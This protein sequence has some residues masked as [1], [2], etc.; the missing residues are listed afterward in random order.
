MADVRVAPSTC[1]H[2]AACK[3]PACSPSG[4]RGSL[5]MHWQRTGGATIQPWDPST[6]SSRP[7]KLPSIVCSAA[8]APCPCRAAAR[9]S[10]GDSKPSPYTRISLSTCTACSPKSAARRVGTPSGG[11]H[12]PAGAGAGAGASGCAGAVAC[13]VAMG[14][15]AGAL[16]DEV[17]G[18]G[19]ALELGGMAGAAPPT[20]AGGMPCCCG[21]MP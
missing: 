14:A 13:G 1:M 18:V 12:S 10:S 6:F 21:G 17:G 5:P 20:E 19:V 16:A 7:A 3:A 11:C 9:R 15:L 4:R 2:V 8:A